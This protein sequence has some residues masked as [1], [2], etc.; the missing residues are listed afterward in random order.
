MICEGVSGRRLALVKKM[1]SSL[2]YEGSWLSPSNISG[3]CLALGGFWMVKK[4]QDA[5]CDEKKEGGGAELPRPG[6]E[7]DDII[8]CWMLFCKETKKMTLNIQKSGN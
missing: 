5:G 7:M 4:M 8:S 6:L 2:V 1:G 3:R